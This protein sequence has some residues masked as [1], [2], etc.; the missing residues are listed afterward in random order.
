[1]QMGYY[2]KLYEVVSQHLWR[3][4]QK[5]GASFLA[6]SQELGLAKETVRKIARRDYKPGGGPNVQSLRVIQN[7]YCLDSFAGM[8][9]L[10]MEMRGELGVMARCFPSLDEEER[11]EIVMYVCDLCERKKVREEPVD[12]GVPPQ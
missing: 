8:E 9:N 3:L 7:H 10:T 11:Q 12:P 5:E 6:M 4:H 1:M 2:E